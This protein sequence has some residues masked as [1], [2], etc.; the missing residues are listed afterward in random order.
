MNAMSTD[1]LNY[2]H[3]TNED[4]SIFEVSLIQSF[5]THLD[6]QFWWNIL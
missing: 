6:K 3:K 2:S 1:V 5:L 4:E